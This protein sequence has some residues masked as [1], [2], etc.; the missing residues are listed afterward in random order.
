MHKVF[1]LIS[2]ILLAACNF[3]RSTPRMVTEAGSATPSNQPCSFNWA[4]QPLPDLSAKVRAAMQTA[5]LNGISVTA[6]AYGENC[7]DTRT[8]EPVSFTAMETDF[9][10]TA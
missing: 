8:N 7:Y 10:V 5:G 9:H 6:E 2:T 3:Q 4:T 1:I